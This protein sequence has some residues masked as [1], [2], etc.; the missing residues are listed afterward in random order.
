LPA[1]YPSIRQ[2][3]DALEDT[4][5]G[6][7]NR[8]PPLPGSPIKFRKY[9]PKIRGLGLDWPST[10]MTMVGRKRLHNFRKLVERVIRGNVPGDIIETGVWRGGASI[11]AR[12]VLDAWQA[13][14]RKIIV[15]DSFE[16]LPP[17]SPGQWPADEA[18]DLH[19]Y[20]ELAVSLE[21]VQANFEQF[22]LLDEQVVFLKGWFRDT[23]S[24]VESSQLAI[25][26]LD[27]DMYEST[28]DPLVHLYDRLSAGGWVIVDD[29]GVIPACK[30]AVHDFFEMK[31]IQPRLRAIDGI[32]IFFRKA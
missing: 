17:P 28:I 1:D 29:Y 22:G 26:R 9:N 2:Q 7:S 5:T 6:A 23:M 13:S 27:G 4:L 8:D 15:A 14:D 21:Q 31:G 12:A 20:D 32:G 11:M 16:G 10:A 30:Q 25:I 19:T 18:S 24:K 3:L